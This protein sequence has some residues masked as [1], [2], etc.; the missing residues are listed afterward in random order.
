MSSEIV[1]VIADFKELM[2]VDLSL[3]VIILKVSIRSPLRVSL[4]EPNTNYNN[5]PSIF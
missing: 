3:L 4:N 1:R 2:F 5:W